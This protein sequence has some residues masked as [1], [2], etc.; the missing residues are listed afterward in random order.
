MFNLVKND[1]TINL[2]HSQTEQ[3]T[4]KEMSTGYSLTLIA[5]VGPVTPHMRDRKA[6][7]SSDT[8]YQVRI[9]THGIQE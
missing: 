8:G 7:S 6:S 1:I 3:G 9:S 4:Q 5:S 2:L